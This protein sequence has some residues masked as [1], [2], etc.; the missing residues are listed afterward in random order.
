MAKKI[1][2]PNSIA[3]LTHEGRPRTYGEKKETHNISVTPTG[4][5]GISKIAQVFGISVSELVEQLGRNILRVEI[6]PDTSSVNE[7]ERLELYQEIV[8]QAANLE[9][10][11]ATLITITKKTS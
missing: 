6:N 1:V 5:G 2:N 4:W 8:E 7:A 10:K 3:N 11:L 9:E